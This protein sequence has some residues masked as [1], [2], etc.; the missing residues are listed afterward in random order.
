MLKIPTN[1]L[2]LQ[3]WVKETIDE[4]MG[5]AQERGLIYTRA[6]QYYYQA[7]YD[8]RAAI[9]NKVKPFVDKLAG[10]LMQPTDVRFNVVFDSS[11]PDD[12]LNRAQLVSE[13]LTADFRVTDSD[14]T[15]AEAVVHSLVNGCYL[16]KI[17]PDGPSFKMAPVHP[18]NFGVLSETILNIDEQEAFCH[19]SYPTLSRL[20]SWLEETHYPNRKSILDRI[21]EARP[22]EKDEELPTYFHQMVVG[23][24]QPLGNPADAQ[25]QSGSSQAAG[26]VNVFPV[27]T[28]WRPQRKI[29]RTV[30]FCELWIK[31]ADRDGDWTTIQAVYPD[32]VIEG[33]HTRRNISRIPGRTPF[34]KVQAQ[35]T[36]GYFWGRSIIADVQMLQDL[37]N[38]RLRD[39]KVMWDRNVN[40][41]QVFSGFTSVTEE[42]YFK[43]IN[44]GGFLND[45]NPNAKA[46]KLVEP[47]PENY[48][49][50]LEFIWKM[51]DEAS[52]FSP[53]MSGQGESGVR[54][55]AHAQTLVRTS[56]PRLIDQAARI[57]RQLAD[58]GYIGLR[59]MQSEDAL[60]YTTDT[61]TEFTLEQ[62]PDNFQVIVDSHSASPAF[63]E[64]NRQ[65]AIALARAGAIDAEDL[66][67]M[68]HPPGAELLLA[69]LRQRKK[70]QAQAA[71]AQQQQE[72]VRDVLQLPQKKQSGAGGRRSRGGGGAGGAGG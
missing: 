29:S 35:P 5:S 40:A 4:T 9:Y 57:E 53:V 72:F 10:F 16:L 64:D 33:E 27:P 52:G 11:E 13:K 28:P 19:V 46:Q 62:I 50:E 24:L 14:I 32:I 17:R 49:Q 6:L 43:I 70:E 54:S 22:T 66:I 59:I 18:Q 51:F 41:P 39:I 30:R 42:A 63:A 31:D 7:S 48:L 20:R 21:L 37:L 56:S 44:E 68:L 36:P 23:G 34:V 38:K 69:R 25:S 67:H 45:P 65:V 15:F 26:I 8:Q 58:S 60:I 2:D 55:G 61:G 47:P 71:Q 1:S 12:V 3:E